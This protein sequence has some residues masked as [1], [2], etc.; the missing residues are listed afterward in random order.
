MKVVVNNF[1]LFFIFFGCTENNGNMPGVYPNSKESRL[2]TIQK[3]ISD[4][5]DY[6]YQ[7]THS[8]Y[9]NDL[10]VEKVSSVTA[11]LITEII[12]FEKFDINQIK[13]LTKDAELN[14]NIAI[15]SFGYDC[16]GTRGFITHPIIVWNYNN[17]TKA[18]NLSE[19]I[20]CKFETITELN[21]REGLYLLMGYEKGDG[22]CFQSITYVIKINENNL[23]VDYQAFPKR[24]YLNLCNG[25]FS[26]DEKNKLL[27]FKL[28]ENTST[29]NLFEA[30][31]YGEDENDSTSTKILYDWISDDYFE[32][33]E[34]SLSFNGNIFQPHY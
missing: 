30:L 26:Y 33:G 10:D 11:K 14:G 17:I 12:N 19:T 8:E 34:F 3:N 28:T 16:G 20:N 5:S 21:S 24:T 13:G 31:L 23:Y 1:I 25:H 18:G 15:Y 9:Y 22:S 4:L 27:N 29:Q 6:V 32:S 2:T 7:P